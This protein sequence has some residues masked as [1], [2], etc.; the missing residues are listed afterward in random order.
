[1]KREPSLK[2]PDS[3][4]GDGSYAFSSFSRMTRECCSEWNYLDDSGLAASLARWNDART[5]K[6]SAKGEGISERALATVG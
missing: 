2:Q 6:P 4:H 3:L 5:R 1:M